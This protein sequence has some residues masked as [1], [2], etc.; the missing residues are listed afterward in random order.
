MGRGVPAVGPG[1]GKREE[2]RG[3]R[4]EGRGKRDPYHELRSCGYTARIPL[5]RIPLARIVTPSQLRG[6]SPHHPPLPSPALGDI[7]RCSSTHPQPTHRCRAQHWGSSPPLRRLAR[8]GRRVVVLLVHHKV[9]VL[10]DKVSQ[11]C[12]EQIY[13]E[14][15][16]KGAGGKLGKGELSSEGGEGREGA[17][18]VCNVRPCCTPP[19]LNCHFAKWRVPFQNTFPVFRNPLSCVVLSP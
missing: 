6:W 18:V 9:V 15:C 4:E 13:E 8:R 14:G 17:S 11:A 10:G 1:R 12:R 5:A 16:L 3:K 7:A 2:G 19:P